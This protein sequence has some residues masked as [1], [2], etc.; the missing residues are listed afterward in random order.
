MTWRETLD[1]VP[2]PRRRHGSRH[3]LGAV[4]ALA[5]CAMLCE[6]TYH[7]RDRPMTDPDNWRLHNELGWHHDQGNL[8]QDRFLGRRDCR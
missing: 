3:P 8:L 6:G 5:V 1:R 7:L 4:V 2:H